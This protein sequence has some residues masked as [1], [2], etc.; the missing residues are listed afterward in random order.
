MDWQT[1]KKQLL[2]N[3]KFKKALKETRLEYEIARAIILARTKKKLTQKQLAEKLET[4]QSVISR[5][6]NAQTTASL[7]FLQ[8]LAN[9]LGGKVEVNFKGI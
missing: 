9:T 5:I 4:Q 1:H 6:E 3:P 7:S 8:R 2:K